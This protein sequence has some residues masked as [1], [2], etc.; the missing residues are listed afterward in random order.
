MQRK[1]HSGDVS[2]AMHCIGI[3]QDIG[4]AIAGGGTKD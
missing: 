1:K 3:V 4:Y 2:K